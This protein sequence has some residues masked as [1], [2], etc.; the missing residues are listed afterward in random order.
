MKVAFLFG[1]GISL[2]AGF[3]DVSKI[4][5]II[6][7]GKGISRHTDSEYY[8][9]PPAYSHIG[10]KED[11][12]VNRIVIFLN[13]LY[14]NCEEYFTT[15]KSEFEPNYEDLY[16]IVSQ[17]HDEI[18]GEQENLI[19]DDYLNNIK[20]HKDIVLD[21]VN[22]PF[23]YDFSFED[24]IDET[25]TYITNIVSKLLYLPTEDIS[26]LN[27]LKNIH[28]DEDLEKIDI[29]SLNH[30]TLLERYLNK[31]KINFC[32]GF[33]E[34]N[35]DF[36]ILKVK[37]FEQNNRINLLKLHGSIDWSRYRENN[38]DWRGDFI[39]KYEVKYGRPP[40]NEK[41]EYLHPIE[42][43][44]RILIGTY[45][46]LI[47]YNYNEF[48]DLICLFKQK[49]NKNIILIISG[50]GFRDKGINAKIIEWF[51]SNDKNK[52]ILIHKNPDGL[53]DKAR[54]AIR[55]KWD[56]WIQEKKLLII[57]KWFEDVKWEELK[58]LLQN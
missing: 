30:D 25:M 42:N 40:K 37:L 20:V 5:E 32:D 26:Y 4:T 7:S 14:K 29:F 8:F 36:R 47:A 6:L 48:S 23:Y 35:G 58:V 55:M 41:G 43:K 13:L 11:D 38:T 46:K 54:G 50:Y 1:S 27:L 16:F 28:D 24:L 2:K 10:I 33:E 51:Y 56:N 45:N 12:N 9:A 3:P 15:I 39:A 34:K 17:L 19:I 53:K 52:F 18:Y 22:K 57:K 49:L 44:P 31:N 21:A